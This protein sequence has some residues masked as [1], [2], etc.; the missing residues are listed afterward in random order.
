MITLQQK[1]KVL[2]KLFDMG[3]KTEKELQSVSMEDILQ[4]PG[5]TISDMK[6]ILEIQ[7]QTKGNKLFSYLSGGIDE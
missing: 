1:V 3:C 5:I 7:K 4:I 2:G 6:I